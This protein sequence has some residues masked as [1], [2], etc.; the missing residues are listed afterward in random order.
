MP[1]NLFRMLNVMIYLF[2]PMLF[3][4]VRMSLI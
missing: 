1:H 3:F 2:Q 4:L